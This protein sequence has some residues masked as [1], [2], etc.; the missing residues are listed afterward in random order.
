M[1][2]PIRTDV[3]VPGEV[4]SLRVVG[5]GNHFSFYINDQWVGEA[6]DNH[7]SRGK[8]GVAIELLASH[9]AAFEFDNFTVSAPAGSSSGS[10]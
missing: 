5:E 9:V 3:I 1:I 2:L 4:N 6:T 8:V 10:E 7:L